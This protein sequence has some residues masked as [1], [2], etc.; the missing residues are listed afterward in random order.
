MIQQLGLRIERK[1]EGEAE[2]WVEGGVTRCDGTKERANKRNDESETGIE[3][4]SHGQ[5][6]GCHHL[7]K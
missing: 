4:K 2:V 3:A 5:S 6:D 7:T 1:C